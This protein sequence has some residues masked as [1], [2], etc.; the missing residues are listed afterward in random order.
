[1][2]HHIVA[3]K[4]PDGETLKEWHMVRGEEQRS[5]CGRDLAEG[6]AELPDDA[7]GTDSARPFCHTCGA[8]YLREVP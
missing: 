5:M 6:A 1:M 4:L 3:E 2:R 8:L 7:W